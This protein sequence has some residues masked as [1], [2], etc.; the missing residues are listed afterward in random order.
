MPYLC[1]YNPLITGDNSTKKIYNIE[2]EAVYN[3]VI[4]LNV[5][6][7]KSDGNQDRT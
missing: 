6:W 4:Q 7:Q 1:R 5:S 2:V 3:K